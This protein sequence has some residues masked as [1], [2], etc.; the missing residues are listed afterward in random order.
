M[1][2]IIRTAGLLL[3]VLFSFL[4]LQKSGVYFGESL[5]NA[6]GPW[7]IDF[8]LEVLIGVEIAALVFIFFWLFFFA[9]GKNMLWGTLL[10]SGGV[11]NLFERLSFGCVTDYI[12][13]FSWFPVFNLADVFLTVA[14]LGLLWENKGVDYR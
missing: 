1:Y 9:Q 12:H 2:A 14:V 6:G 7:G 3:A 4:I 13:V 10:F 8:P 11:S 5:C